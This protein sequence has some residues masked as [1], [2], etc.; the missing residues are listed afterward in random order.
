MSPPMPPL[1]EPGELPDKRQGEPP[2]DWEKT[3][4][5]NRSSLIKDF[6]G[7]IE[8]QMRDGQTAQNTIKD[9]AAAA[10]EQEFSPSEVSAMK[11]IARLMLKDDLAKAQQE[12]QAL[13]RI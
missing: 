2:R 1:E 6:V 11:K 10:E 7:Q 8:D 5:L 12:L 9:I 4:D 13:Q 3:L